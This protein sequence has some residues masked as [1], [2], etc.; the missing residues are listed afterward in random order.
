MLS[1]MPSPPFWDDEQ[2]LGRYR[3]S[4]IVPLNCVSRGQNDLISVAR[5]GAEF[6]SD[7]LTIANAEQHCNDDLEIRS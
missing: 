7:D 2:H 4:W 1:V 6:S 5:T 3:Q